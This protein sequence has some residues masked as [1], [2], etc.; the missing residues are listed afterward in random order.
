MS[1]LDLSEQWTAAIQRLYI[2]ARDTAEF[3]TDR[4]LGRSRTA[5]IRKLAAA[6][7]A[8]DELDRAD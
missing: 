1:R 3:V 8:I 2:A 6:V 5:S 7:A 4:P